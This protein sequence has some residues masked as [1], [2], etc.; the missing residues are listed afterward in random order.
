MA[1]KIITKNK[2]A[3]FDYEILD[4]YEAGIKLT[5]A[6]VK[7]VKNGGISIN[8]AYIRSVN[9][10]LH[11]WNASI[12]PYKHAYDPD[13]D[14]GR[15]RQLLLHKREM[16]TLAMKS[17]AERLTIIPTKVYLSHGLVK[18]E[19]AT[20]KGRKKH[21]KQRRIKE[22]DLNRELHREKRKFMIK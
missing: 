7:S 19:I 3:Y 15:S 1:I 18:L 4:T 20:A 14:P 16:E 12:R 9:G 8:E 11:L 5:G 10:T 2:K 13:Y 17:T 21:D 6:E 22:R